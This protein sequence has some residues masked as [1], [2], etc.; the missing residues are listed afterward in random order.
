MQNS[1]EIYEQLIQLL[2]EQANPLAA[3]VREEVARGYLI[4]GSGLPAEEREARKQ[5]LGD[6]RLPQIGA[7]EKVVVP[8]SGDE[9][10]ALLCRTL[11]TSARTMTESRRALLQ[12]VKTDDDVA[13]GSER[14]SMYE[15]SGTT[16][17]LDRD[18]RIHFT[19]PDGADGADEEFDLPV[20]L[21]K[22]ELALTTVMSLL[23]PVL[24]EVR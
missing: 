9:R 21:S 12:L 3:Q 6:S 24:E 22:A 13:Q 14:A 1:D 20:E 8:Y 16:A 5:R 11:L 2:D 23:A 4:D 17:S 7:K 15:M 19:S 18:T 10:L